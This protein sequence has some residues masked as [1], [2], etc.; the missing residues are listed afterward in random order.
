LPNEVADDVPA[1]LSEGEYVVPAD[2][3]RWHGL[4]TLEMLR[5]EAKMALG[6]MAEDGRIKTFGDEEPAEENEE[7][8][9]EEDET[10][11]SEEHEAEEEDSEGVMSMPKVTDIDDNDYAK[12]IKA[13]D[14]GDVQTAAPK[15]TYYSYTTK[16]NP[17]T[18]RYEFVPVEV[19]TGEVVTQETYD[20][21]RASRYSVKSVMDEIYGGLG[22]EDSPAECGEGYVWDEETQSCVPEEEKEE[23]VVKG[24]LQDP[25]SGEGPQAEGPKKVTPYSEQLTT[26]IAENLGPLSAEQLEDQE[27]DTLAQKAVSR[28]M[29]PTEVDTRLMGLPFGIAIMGAKY[30]KDIV[31]VKRAALTRSEEFSSDP[32]AERAYNYTWSDQTN[33]FVKVTPSTQITELG[34][35][36]DGSQYVS[37]WNQLGSSGKEYNITRDFDTLEEEDWNDIFDQIDKDFDAMPA[38]SGENTLADPDYK[39]STGTYTPP[40]KNTDSGGDGDSGSANNGLGSGNSSQ[41]EMPTPTISDYT[42][43]PDYEGFGDDDDGGFS[44]NP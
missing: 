35:S 7:A 14:G 16:L 32:L 13:A 36:A 15:P 31:D 28:M 23:D 33:S 40:P 2:V 10:A 39:P 24:P 18:G 20:P 17:E 38:I 9:Y 37:D 22:A 42:P 34:V 41:S 30:A 6:M 29:Q 25:S 5:T 43:T 11:E 1:L 4:K 3:V 12:P 27:G 44:D 19:E 8:E 21:A 26:K